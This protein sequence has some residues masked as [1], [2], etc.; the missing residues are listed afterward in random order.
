M[1]VK[2]SSTSRPSS[3]QPE[4]DS[5][6]DADA[7]DDSQYSESL[8]DEDDDGVGLDDDNGG[9]SND[10][11]DDGIDDNN[12]IDEDDGAEGS[13][14]ARPGWADAL[15]RV[16][17]RKAAPLRD[18]TLIK[19][20]QSAENGTRKVSRKETARLRRKHAEWE[21]LGRRKVDIL[22]KE[23]ERR[24]NRIATRG[25]V[26]LF[27]AVRQHQSSLTDQLDAA[28]GSTIKTERVLA[29]VGKQQLMQRLGVDLPQQT[30]SN[31][32]RPSADSK[33]APGGWNVL[34][35]DP[36]QEVS[37]RDWNRSEHDEQS[38][39]EMASDDDSDVGEDQSS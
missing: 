5:A 20:A 19:R 33:A 8:A 1:S 29:S 39:D 38:D 7:D 21:Q 30:A 11:D 4:W 28:G 35:R 9:A 6:S 31:D 23:H 17:N 22:D 13:G 26:Q 25:V 24:L 18:S 16:L 32:T 15:S 34:N 12:G 3:K 37:M 2:V 27:N 10:D 14:G 36:A